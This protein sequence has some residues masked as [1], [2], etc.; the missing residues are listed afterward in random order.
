[1][2][3][4]KHG[5]FKKI[6]GMDVSYRALKKASSRLHLDEMSPRMRERIELIQGSLTY[7]DDRLAGYDAAVL[8]EVI[9]HLE[10]ERLAAFERVVFEF[11]RPQS[12]ILTTPNAEYN[13]LY[14]SLEG[15]AMRHD[16]HRF[17]WSR[18][19]FQKWVDKI[20]ETYEYDPQISA[21]G[22]VDPTVGP[23]SQMVVFTLKTALA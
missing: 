4:L 19:E 5:Q 9:E 16:D 8:V 17:E 10:L 22:E 3:L 23:S 13:Q 15:G 20:S 18:S 1:R 14:P 7:H 2:M 6:L 12:V 21:I 11:A